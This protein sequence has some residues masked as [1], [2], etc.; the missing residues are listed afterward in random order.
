MEFAHGTSAVI[1]EEQ[2]TQHH[3]PYHMDDGGKCPPECGY[4]LRTAD[5]FSATAIDAQVL[6]NSGIQLQ[7]QDGFG[8]W[9]T[10]LTRYPREHPDEAVLDGMGHGPVRLV[11]VGRHT[12]RAAGRLTAMSTN[13]TARKLPLLA[14]R[15]TRFGDV[16]AVVD[17]T[18]NLT[19]Q[20]APGDTVNLEFGWVPVPEG[21]VRELF[22]LSRGV[23]TANLPAVLQEAVPAMFA[24]RLMRPNPFAGTASLGFDLPAASRVQLEVL[25]AQGRR[26]RMMERQFSAGSHS[27]EWD[28][29]NEA[30]GRVGPGVYFYRLKA[31]VHRATGRITRLP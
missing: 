15:H 24:A 6:A 13:F 28:G 17:T 3:E 9:R 27:I 21:Q 25:D 4:P 10:V 23:Y 20:L 18:G 8:G 29:R 12:V 2:S 19:S 26:V 14:A 11:F 31:G 5:R 30:G 16:A 7:T 1:G 22:L